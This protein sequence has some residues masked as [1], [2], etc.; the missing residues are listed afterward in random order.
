MESASS[1][2]HKVVGNCRIHASTAIIHHRGEPSQNNKMCPFCWRLLQIKKLR[3]DGFSIIYC[4]HIHSKCDVQ[5]LF[6]NL[7]HVVCL[8]KSLWSVIVILPS[9]GWES[10]PIHN[11]IASNPLS[12]PLGNVVLQP[13]PTNSSAFIVTS[14]MVLLLLNDSV[15]IARPNAALPLAFSGTVFKDEGFQWKSTFLGG[16]GCGAVLWEMFQ[17]AVYGPVIEAPSASILVPT[18]AGALVGCGTQVRCSC[19]FS[20]CASERLYSAHLRRR[21][22]VEFFIFCRGSWGPVLSLHAIG[23]QRASR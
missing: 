3:H 7:I 14:F 9:S 20:F 18:I 1:A 11:S 12:N 23:S 17:P 21:I 19:I 10:G 13:A 6:M 4:I 8:G 15:F 2:R 22:P 16:L 5:Y